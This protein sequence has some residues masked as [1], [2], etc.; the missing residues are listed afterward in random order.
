M[1][2]R[3]RDLAHTSDVELFTPKPDESLNGAP[4]VPQEEERH[5]RFSR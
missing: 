5:A 4:P 2:A 3:P 1:S